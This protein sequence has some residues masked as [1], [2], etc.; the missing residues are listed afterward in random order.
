VV[1]PDAVGGYLPDHILPTDDHAPTGK[2]FRRR[3]GSC[4]P[5]D[6]LV[7]GE[8]GVALRKQGAWTSIAW[9]ELV[10]AE[11]EAPGAWFLLDRRG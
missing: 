6:R 8:T 9:E 11:Y 1:I 7:V 10:F 2:H 4:G 3:F 5:V